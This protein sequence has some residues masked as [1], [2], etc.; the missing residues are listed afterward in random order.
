MELGRAE[1]FSDPTDKGFVEFIQTLPV[2]VFRERLDG[3]ILYC[4]KALADMFGFESSAEL[5]EHPMTV[6]Y[7]S[8][9]ERDMLLSAV[10]KRG[11]VV[12]APLFLDG[13]TAAPF[14]AASQPRLF[15][16]RTASRCTWTAS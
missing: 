9:E 10:M 2:A 11:R 1:L 4:N 7:R 16:T 12:D 3:R 14:G 15:S 5:M 8:A 13:E 6:F